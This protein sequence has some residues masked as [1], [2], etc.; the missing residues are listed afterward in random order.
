MKSTKIISKLL[1][2]LNSGMVQKPLHF[3]LLDDSQNYHTAPTPTN[4]SSKEVLP[5]NSYLVIPTNVTH[6]ENYAFAIKQ[7]TNIIIP[8]NVTSIGE[9]AFSHNLLTDLLIPA[10][11]TSIEEGAFAHNMLTIL[12]LPHGLTHIDDYAFASN[13]L[14]SLTISA[15]VTSIGDG[16]FYNNQLT[17]ITIPDNV[18]TIG[19]DAFARNQAKPEDLTI[20]AH[21]QSPARDYAANHGHTFQA[22]RLYNDGKTNRH[23]PHLSVIGNSSRFVRTSY[24]FERSQRKWQQVRS[25]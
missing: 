22:T 23:V 6:I 13:L 8:T 7:L 20:I 24:T 5:I 1:T 17:H 3:K 21:Q 16:A 14:T 11:V 4:N 15:S 18:T 10:S 2:F 25:R 19:A 12:S 9:E